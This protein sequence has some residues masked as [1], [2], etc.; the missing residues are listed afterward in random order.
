[1][2]EHPIVAQL[3]T[4][5]VC[6]G[7]FAMIGDPFTAEVLGSA[8]FDWVMVDMEHGPVPLETAAAMVT[9]LRTTPAAP[10]VRAAWNDPAQIQRALD[11]GC[12]GVLVPVVNDAAG[13][14]RAV[15]DA[16]FPPLGERSRGAVRP[17]LAFATDAMSYF[18]QANA[19]TLL[20]VQIETAAAVEQADA[21]CA[22]EGVDGVFVGP[23]DLAASTLQR[24]PDVWKT[25]AAYMDRIAR[26]ARAARAAGKFAGFLARDAAMAK[27][28]IALGY[29]FLGMASD[30]ALLLSGA[31]AAARAIREAAQ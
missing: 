1:M 29:T 16:K 20:I 3:R 4:G 8:G 6:T 18:E 22:V 11:L 14:R 23:N 30:A 2:R 10:F 24:W 28:V 19:Q 5:E 15:L 25:D 9:A 13:A 31:A 17:N 12:I 21:I 27:E 7:I 26:V